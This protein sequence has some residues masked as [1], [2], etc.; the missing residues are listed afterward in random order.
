[1]ISR[2]QGSRGVEGSIWAQKIAE[3]EEKIEINKRVK[4]LNDI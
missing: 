1:V 3:L 2:A 4:N